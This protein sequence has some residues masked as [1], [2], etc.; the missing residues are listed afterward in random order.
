MGLEPN[1][2]VGNG[3]FAKQRLICIGDGWNAN[4][5]TILLSYS[6]FAR[7][8][9]NSREVTQMRE[10]SNSYSAALNTAHAVATQSFLVQ[11]QQDH[12]PEALSALILDQGFDDM[13]MSLELVHDYHTDKHLTCLSSSS[14]DPSVLDSGSAKHLQ[15]RAVV[16]DSHNRCALSGF[17]GST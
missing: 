9:S 14:D 15:K 1:N 5:T 16:T 11:Y 17:D 10:H 3:V 2:I 8:H 12:G 6:E 13:K 7:E 4:T